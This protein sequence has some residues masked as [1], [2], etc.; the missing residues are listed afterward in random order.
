MT[1]G[2]GKATLT[3]PG[4]GQ[5]TQSTIVGAG[6]EG[7]TICCLCEC[8]RHA[9]EIKDH[10]FGLNVDKVNSV[11]MLHTH[12]LHENHSQKISFQRFET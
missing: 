4:N 6:L 3:A 5:H 7:G 12:K 2:N 10:V 8:E 11:G 1:D 9:A